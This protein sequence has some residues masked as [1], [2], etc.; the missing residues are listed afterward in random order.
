[1]TNQL[2]LPESPETTKQH[3]FYCAWKSVTIERNG[4]TLTLDLITQEKGTKGTF[5]GLGPDSSIDTLHD[6]T[7]PSFHNWIRDLFN[8]KVFT[9]AWKE[10]VGDTIRSSKLTEATRETFLQTFRENVNSI[11]DETQMRVKDVDY[12]LA[13]AMR[14][15]KKGDKIGGVE[16]QKEAMRLMEIKAQAILALQS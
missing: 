9:R 15:I 1:M 3:K 8:E 4:Q 6:F 5:P 16:A 10:A 7:G 11:L 12:W 2:T 13:E 14:R